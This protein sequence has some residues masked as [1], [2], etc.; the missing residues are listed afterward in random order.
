M[1]DLITLRSGLSPFEA[2]VQVHTDEQFSAYLMEDPALFHMALLQ[3]HS[4][5]DV[6]QGVGTLSPAARLHLS[7]LLHIV[8]QR[9]ESLQAA[10]SDSTMLIVS[11]LSMAAHDV[12][13]EAAAR[14]HVAGLHKI[15]GLRGGVTSLTHNDHR[16]QR[17]VCRYTLSALASLAQLLTSLLRV[18]LSIAL[19]FGS[20]PLFFSHHL[21]WDPYLADK[22][23][24]RRQRTNQ[25]HD[26]TTLELNTFIDRTID[27]KLRSIWSD[28][29]TFASL[30][31]L[32]HQTERKLEPSLINEIMVSTMYRLLH[33]TF[34]HPSVN[35]IIRLSLLAFSSTIF[36]QGQL[37]TRRYQHLTFKLRTSL[38][39]S[40][41][42][43]PHETPLPVR[44]WLTMMLSLISPLCA[45]DI[46]LSGAIDQLVQETKITTWID[47][48]TMLKSVMWID[49]LHDT[50][51]KEIVETSL[52]RLST[53][54]NNDAQK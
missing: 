3:V 40:Q 17:K 27:T 48:R 41:T 20:A 2:C 18:D 46:W 22:N 8:Q 16:M 15:V 35:E 36:L 49:V 44:F 37:F 45:D 38:V 14:K 1:L 33:L 31:N 21:S 42:Q 7:K 34:L 39:Q 28:L 26:K 30:A 24:I 47:A 50:P 25:N 11:A 10:L 43:S 6:K 19:R 29:R 5:I 9:L 53:N 32:A 54:R 13:D 52:S 23:I 4:Y 12:G 51:G